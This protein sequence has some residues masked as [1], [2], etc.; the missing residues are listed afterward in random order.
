MKLLC[1]DKVKKTY[2]AVRF[3]IIFNNYG[4]FLIYIEQTNK[5]L[6]FV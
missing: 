6:L 1:Q 4:N 5:F 2:F 3:H